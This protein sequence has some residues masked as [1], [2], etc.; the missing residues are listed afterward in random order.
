MEKFVL[1]S[2]FDTPDQPYLPKEVLWRQKE[3]F[4]YTSSQLPAQSGALEAEGAVQV[5]L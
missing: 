4:R 5:D 1:R 3:Q 2:A